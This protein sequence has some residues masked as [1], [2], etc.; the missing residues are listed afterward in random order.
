MNLHE[1]DKCHHT[2]ISYVSVTGCKNKVIWC[3][4]KNSARVNK[5]TSISLCNRFQVLQNLNSDDNEASSTHMAM[6]NNPSA[7]DT[8]CAYE[9]NVRDK[10]LQYPKEC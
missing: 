1:I 9:N 2:N 7:L 6:H 4:Q 8:Q 3:T 10:A 5:H